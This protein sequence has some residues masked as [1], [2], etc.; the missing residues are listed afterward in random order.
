MKVEKFRIHLIYNDKD[1]YGRLL[2]LEQWGFKDYD[3]IYSYF[4]EEVMN[5]NKFT[6]FLSSGDKIFINDQALKNS[7]I[8][9]EKICYDDDK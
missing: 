6:F 3:E 5:S 4:F 1:Y 2:T 7:I 9:I 8:I